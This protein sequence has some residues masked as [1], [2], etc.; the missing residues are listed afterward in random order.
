M[1]LND[2]LAN[3]LSHI[4]LEDKKGKKQVTVRNN[5]NVIKSV[6]KILM[7][8]RYLGEFKEV[9][10]GRGGFLEV[11]LLGAIN[12]VGVVK[13]RHSVKAGDYKKFEKRYLP[14]FGFGLLIVS[15]NKGL[16]TQE[17]AIKNNVGGKL[18][19]FVY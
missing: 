12:K 11:N 2:P 17:E 16:M 8:N 1:S 15:T 14:A 18:I 7:E 10:D 13:P 19:A 6:F 3:V 9:E 4:M 5:S